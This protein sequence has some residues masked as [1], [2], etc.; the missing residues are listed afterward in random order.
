[1]HTLRVGVGLYLCLPV[2]WCQVGVEAL[3]I[4]LPLDLS[5]GSTSLGTDGVY[6]LF[7]LTAF[8]KVGGLPRE[9]KGSE[10]HS[11]GYCLTGACISLWHG[12]PQAQSRA[13]H[14]P[15]SPSGRPTAWAGVEAPPHHVGLEPQ[16]PSSSLFVSWSRSWGADGGLLRLQGKR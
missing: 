16:P 4:L 11:R 14:C 9:P 8:S 10:L 12:T 3:V 1:M 6:F 5:A 7:V 2:S 15:P 13:P